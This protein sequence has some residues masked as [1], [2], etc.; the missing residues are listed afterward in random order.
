MIQIKKIHVQKGKRAIVISDIHANVALFKRLLDK[1]NYTS[2]DYLIINGDMCEKGMNSLEVIE[3]IRMLSKEH[4]HVYIT[5][6][7]CDVL[8]RYVENNVKGII[9]YMERQKYSILNEMLKLYHNSIVDYKDLRELEAFYRRNFSEI[10]N[11]IERLPNVIEMENYIIV[12]AGVENRVD[13]QNTSED[14]SLSNDAFYEKGHQAD[15]VVIVG[16]WPVVNYR[17]NQIS[18]HMPLIDLEKKIIAIDGGNQIKKDGQ[19]NALILQNESYQI[20]YVDELE[21]EAEI[22]KE[23]IDTTKRVGTVVYPHYEMKILHQE[24]YFTLCE[25]H[26]LG[27]K[28]WVKNEYL[29]KDESTVQCK[30]DVSTTFLSVKEKEKVSIIDYSTEGY[31][32]VKNQKGEVGWIPKDCL[33][34]VR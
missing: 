3:Y 23:H 26:G 1:V 13:W 5:K 33:E 8:F 30:T 27:I 34:V 4:P 16:H 11:W 12:H 17:A 6:G 19:L 32:L 18:S 21:Q 31:I 14:F 28:Q 25:N 2:D 29:R 10:L 7:N 20:S 9:S 22:C 15:K 24:R